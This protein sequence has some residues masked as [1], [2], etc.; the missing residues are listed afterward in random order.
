MWLST[1]RK[2]SHE[3]QE[4]ASIQ[5]VA[6]NCF[7]SWA[8]LAQVRGPGT[9]TWWSNWWWVCSQH[10]TLC[11][12]RVVQGPCWSILFSQ[13]RLKML[14]SGQIEVGTHKSAEG[15]ILRMW[16]TFQ[17]KCSCHW[18][19]R[20]VWGS[21][22]S[23][24]LIQWRNFLL[25]WR[26]E[27]GWKSWH[28]EP[29]LWWEVRERGGREPRFEFWSIHWKCH[30]C[31]L[32]CRVAA[33]SCSRFDAACPRASLCLSF[34]TLCAVT[35]RNRW[36]MCL[37]PEWKSWN[38]GKTTSIH[39]GSCCGQTFTVQQLWNVTRRWCN[40]TF[41]KLWS[42]ILT[43]AQTMRQVCGL[44][45]M[46]PKVFWKHTV[47]LKAFNFSW[48]NLWL[49]PTVQVLFIFLKVTVTLVT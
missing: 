10:W 20:L 19:L 5:D 11:C 16:Q 46:Q 38:W 28:A 42:L 6:L 9:S 29:W 23:T 8:L 27:S 21:S 32:I 40:R 4:F 34:I 7:N 13:C 31:Q 36:A 35:K 14:S 41:H 30:V 48:W 26:P 2:A 43:H 15:P 18:W 44:A 39:L 25:V 1:A 22:V 49:C 45:K 12:C 33:S 47:C 24:A 37:L 3:D 17:T